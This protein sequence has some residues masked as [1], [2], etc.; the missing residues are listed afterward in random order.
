MFFSI[1]FVQMGHDSV[2]IPFVFQFG[3]VMPKNNQNGEKL[4][5]PILA[6]AYL[7]LDIY[8]KSIGPR[9]GLFYQGDF[10]D[11]VC[12]QCAS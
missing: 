3:Y 2:I 6:L 9:L 5:T 10:H 8:L 4:G 11:I 7:F 12:L 1:G